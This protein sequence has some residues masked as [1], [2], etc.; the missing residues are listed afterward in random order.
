M[1]ATLF[2]MFVKIGFL[3]F[4]GGYPMMALIYEEGQRLLNLTSGEFADMLAL[5]LLSSGP[6]AINGATYIGYIKGGIIGSIVATF[7][8][9]VP[10]LI[11]VSIVYFFLSKIYENPYIQGFLTAIKISCAGIL[12]ATALNLAREI[13]ILESGN[14]AE[15]TYFSNI[16]WGSILIFCIGLISLIKYKVNPIHFIFASAI[17]GIIL[18]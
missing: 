1:Y 11:L 14:I 2:I 9:C 18:F 6:V 16:Q 13:F 7:G 17:L 10:S 8:V 5:E 3:S 12:L 4:G 15:I